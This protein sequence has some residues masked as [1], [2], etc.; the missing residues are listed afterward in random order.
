[1]LGSIDPEARGADVDEPVQV[2]GNPGAH[3]LLLQ[4]QVQ[5]AHQ[6]AV[7]DLHTNSEIAFHLIKLTEC[8]THLL[9]ILCLLQCQIKPSVAFAPHA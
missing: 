2:C 1:M 3:R 8:S 4:G 6:A 5:Q 7:P 9:N